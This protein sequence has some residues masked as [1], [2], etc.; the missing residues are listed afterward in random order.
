[1]QQYK[2]IYEDASL[3]VVEK[4]AGV[5]TSTKKI[6][7]QD[8][9][10]LLRNAR[11]RKKEDPYIGMVHR[12]DQP[13]GGLMV[14]AKTKKAAAHLSKQ[15]QQ[16]TIGKSYYALVHK[17]NALPERGTL[18]HYLTFDAKQN[19]SFVSDTPTSNSKKAV[20][21]YV[22]CEQNEELALVDI[23]LH[24][25]R[26]HQIR[27]QFAHIGCPL[28]GDAR[29]GTKEGNERLGLYSYALTFQ[30]PDTG[31]QMEFTNPSPLTIERV[32]HKMKPSVF[33]NCL[34]KE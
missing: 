26:H 29:Y 10:S 11:I 22:I 7:Q 32:Y 3:I 20:L 34:Q 16:R 15:V 17:K 1:M 2:V 6:G 23:C 24:T 27:A 9:E 8:M 28:V 30:H 33:T 14:W 4:P 25:G 31:K 5:A 12:L 21:D 19:L 13:V 18:E